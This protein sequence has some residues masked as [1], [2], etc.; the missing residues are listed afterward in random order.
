MRVTVFMSGRDCSGYVE[1]AV[2]GVAAQSLLAQDAGDELH[3]LLV[4]DASGDDTAAVAAR[5]LEEHLPGRHTLIT[6]PERW[7]KARSAWTHLRALDLGEDDVVA[8]VDADDRLVDDAVL[9]DLL[10]MYRQGYDVVWTRYRSDD[11]RI[12]DTG[13][14]DPFVPARTQPWRSSH[15]FTFRGVLL[16]PV[17]EHL[18]QDET[19]AWL[20]AACDMAVAYPVLDQTRRWGF[21]DRVAY[22]YTITN[23]LSLHNQDP[24]AI[25][26]N[27]RAQ[28]RAAL[29]VRAQE[30]LPCTR[31]PAQTPAVLHEQIGQAIAGQRRDLQTVTQ[32]VVQAQQQLARVPFVARAVERLEVGEGIPGPWLH[33]VGGWSLDV[34]FL[35]HLAGVLDRFERPRVLELGSGAGSRVLGRMVQRRGGSIVSVEHDETWHGRT[36]AQLS[37]AGLD[38]TSRVQLAPLVPVEVAGV[39]GRF[40][41]TAWLTD[42]DRFD[43]VI[44]DGPP[45]DT[46]HLAR[47]PALPAFAAH[48]SPDGFE[49]FLDDYERGPERE[50]VEIWRS[51]APDLTYTELTF[52]KKVCSITP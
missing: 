31:F 50:I 14:L 25:G 28:Q 45:T 37:E 7:G 21:L 6:N 24:Q 32:A 44:V 22:E 39:S 46:G 3:L 38:G 13:P 8:M 11:G 48:L 40:Y 16:M 1:R 15:L 42:A 27:S 18:M 29:V 4:D 47:L 26:L 51:M 23:P 19:G 5:A 9:V 2:A 12:G 17:P 30:P 34:D 43:V 41:D 10:A 20:T 52:S 49:V 36:S 33:Q 35:A